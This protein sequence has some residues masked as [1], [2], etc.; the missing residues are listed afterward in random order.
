QCEALDRVLHQGWKEAPAGLGPWIDR[1]FASGWYA[2]L[3]RGVGLPLGMLNDP[4]SR[5]AL[6]GYS[7][8]MKSRN[9]ANYCA[10][11]VHQLLARGEDEA[12]L[13]QLTT[14]LGLS[15]QL[16]NKA[17][18]TLFSA[19]QSVEVIA[20]EGFLHWSA[21]SCKPP[22]L[23]KALAQLSEHD[24]QVPPVADVLK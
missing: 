19:G 12:A 21:S 4:R 2:E 8:A 18:L 13:E 7:E 3:R 17:N 10:L 22:L 14:L 20:T 15:R 11:R 24:D 5:K 16:R 1:L 6:E 9:V 23:L